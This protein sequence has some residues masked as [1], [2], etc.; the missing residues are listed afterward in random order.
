MAFDVNAFVN[1][2]FED[3]VTDVPVPD[4]R[5]WFGGSDPVWRVRGLTGDELGRVNEAVEKYKNVN[6]L[7]SSMIG[8]DPGQKAEAV[9]EALGIAGQK[10]PESIVRE[11]ELVVIGS[12]DPVCDMSLAVKL[13][14]NFPI[15]FRQIAQAILIA[16]GKGRVPGKLK[17]S[18]ETMESEPASV[19][20]TSEEN[21]CTNAGLTS[22]HAAG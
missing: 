2:R 18:G 7:I 16:T 13:K 4:L 17:A 6:A 5:Q 8:K 19:S 12:V 10:T 14:D 9:K 22:F 1:E 15:E 3:R 11:L 20:V 21:S